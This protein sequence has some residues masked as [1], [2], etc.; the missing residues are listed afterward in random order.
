MHRQVFENH[1]H[2]ITVIQLVIMPGIINR[3]PAFRIIPVRQ[4]PVVSFQAD[5]F[6]PCH[7]EPDAMPDKEPPSLIRIKKTGQFIHKFTDHLSVQLLMSTD[8]KNRTA[9]FISL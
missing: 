3:L 4:K 9:L 8:L 1:I 7:A 2:R 6:I 5:H